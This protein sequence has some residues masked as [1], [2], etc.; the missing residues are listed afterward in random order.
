MLYEHALYAGEVF[1]TIA[2]RPLATVGP[3]DPLGPTPVPVEIRVIPGQ[4]F[5][6]GTIDVAPMPPGVNLRK[7]GLIPGAAA[8]SQT[9]LRAEA[10]LLEAWLNEGHPL[11]EIGPRDTIADHRTNRLKAAARGMMGSKTRLRWRLGT[12]PFSGN[13]ALLHSLRSA[14]VGQCRARRTRGR[15]CQPHHQEGP[16][17]HRHRGGS[18]L[19]THHPRPQRGAP[20]DRLRPSVDLRKNAVQAGRA[21]RGI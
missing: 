5:V 20:A 21:P 4:P 9:I 15:H 11:A 17:P 6:F 18:R 14:G 3:F 10:A 19:L 16:T 12:H 2:G 13:H 7:L 8:G 1:V